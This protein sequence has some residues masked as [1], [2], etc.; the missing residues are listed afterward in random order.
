[1]RFFYDRTPVIDA[2]DLVRACGAA[3]LASPSRSTVPLLNLLRHEQDRLTAAVAEALSLPPTGFDA[4]H[5]EYTVTPPQ[6]VG[7]ASHTDAL[8]VSQD[9]AV[10]VEAKWTEPRY[11]SVESW[12]AD[13]GENR[14]VVLEGWLSLVNG[15]SAAHLTPR[16]VSQLPYQLIHRAASACSREEG[17]AL[18]YLV[19]WGAG[20]ASPSDWVLEDLRQLRDSVGDASPLRF[21]EMRVELDPTPAY[22]SIAALKPGGAET[23]KAVLSALLGEPLLKIKSVSTTE[24]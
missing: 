17:P 18:V 6:G 3:A 22:A 2:A 24:V 23:G 20:H 8:L 10:A 13:G 7:K 19:F 16:D 4:V 9:Y 11:P 21:S 14:N 12:L 1:M 15:R 5:L